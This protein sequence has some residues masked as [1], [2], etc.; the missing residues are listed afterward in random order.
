M[1]VKSMS[2]RCCSFEQLQSYID[3]QA[4][5]TD[6]PILQYV[7]DGE[8]V[9]EA[10][11]VNATYRKARKN[12]VSLYH[13]VLAF[14]AADTGKIRA[15]ILQDIA[16]EYLAQR[17]PGALAY[18][19]IHWHPKPHVHL[20][21]S[22]N[23]FRSPQ[24]TR[25]S[26]KRFQD[27]KEHIE[28]YQRSRYAELDAS[29]VDHN[30][31]YLQRSEAE[32]KY[33]GRGVKEQLKAQIL[34]A[35]K[36]PVD[37]VLARIRTNNIELYTRYGRYAGVVYNKKRYRWKTLGLNSAWEQYLAKCRMLSQREKELSV[38]RGRQNIARQQHKGGREPDDL[39]PT[40]LIKRQR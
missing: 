13:E 14:H 36:Q 10:F 21:I 6:F 28:S 3:E 12:G 2:R 34:G 31:R 38:T 7:Q 15:S 11:L 5:N 40:N 9:S 24:A 8:K 4:I 39:Y 37:T 35:L 26:K 23:L 25:I 20:M 16:Y 33:R 18:G 30:K 19:R 29:R 32:A 22:G 27:I 1:I 17:A